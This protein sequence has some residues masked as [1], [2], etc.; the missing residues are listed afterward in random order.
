MTGVDAECRMP[1]GD[2]AH[3]KPVIGITPCSRVEDYVESVRRA[4]AEPLVLSNADDPE[5]VLDRV[6]AILLTGGL[7]VDPSLYSAAPHETTEPDRERD[8]FE[9]PLSRQALA[10]D[11]PVFAICRGVQVLN[12]AAGG[13]LVQDIPS[14]V[15][16]D[17]DH[18]IDVPKD[19]IAHPVRVTRGTRLAG[20]LGPS[21]ALDACA[22]NSRHHQ[23]VGVVAPS[24]VVSAVSP[25]GVVEAIERPASDFC[26]GVQWH[27]ENFWRT[28]EFAPLFDAFVAA[29]ARRMSPS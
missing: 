22:V 9:I 12:V 20:A 2:M 21:T 3:R 18:A 23:A 1:N 26:V 16:S 7:D 19:A 8:R 15:A 17:L 5:A 28:G 24:F 13:T 25:D 27:P 6:D 29:A 4:G 11:L 14:A 10:R